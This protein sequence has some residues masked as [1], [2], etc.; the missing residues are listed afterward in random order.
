MGTLT[1]ADWP[2]FEDL[3]LLHE[4][5][6]DLTRRI[7]DLR[8]LKKLTP[9]D[10]MLLQSY[11][12]RRRKSVT[13]FQKLSTEFGG[14]ASARTRVRIPSGQG[15]FPFAGG[16]QGQPENPLDAARRQLTGA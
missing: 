11:E 6:L 5:K 4:E 10:E 7:N 14:T 2:V 15:E 8:A 12:G 13:Q 16:A 1:D 9:K 3:C